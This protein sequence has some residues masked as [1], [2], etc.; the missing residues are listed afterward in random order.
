MSRGV[1]LPLKAAAGFDRRQRFD[2][3]HL[4][5]QARG[6][7]HETFSTTITASIQLY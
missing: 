1:V 7:H 5:A 4:R 6:P 3:H 2:L